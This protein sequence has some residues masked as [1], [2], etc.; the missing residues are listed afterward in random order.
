[1]AEHMIGITVRDC[2]RYY[3]YT[4]GLRQYLIRTLPDKDI[5]STVLTMRESKH[6]TAHIKVQCEHFVVFIFTKH[7]D[8]YAFVALRACQNPSE[9]TKEKMRQF[10]DVCI[11]AFAS[12][13]F[14][15]HNPDHYR[16]YAF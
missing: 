3:G 10:A 11:D 13:G 8:K 14:D 15:K 6:G 5:T 16:E 4:Y 2:Q 1:M 9:H 12:P 7:A